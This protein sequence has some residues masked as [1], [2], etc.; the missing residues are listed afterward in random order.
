MRRLIM[1]LALALLV[2]PACNEDS[3]YERFEQRK[4]APSRPPVLEQ[5]SAAVPEPNAALLFGAGLVLFAAWR[6]SCWER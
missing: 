2:G 3:E 5:P 1:I 4:S 6:R